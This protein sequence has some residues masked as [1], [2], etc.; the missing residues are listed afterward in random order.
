M[1]TTHAL[2]SALV[3]YLDAVKPDASI[4]VVDAR[5]RAEIALPTLAADIDQLSAHSRAL[6]HVM[7]CNVEIRLRVHAGDDA[8]A[9]VDNWNDQIESALNDPAEV[10]ALV[11]DGI[12]IDYWLYSGSS[13]DWDESM[14][15]TTFHAECLA[16]VI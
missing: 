2:K 15:E 3:A 11:S 6:A 1:N 16:R 5:Q 9:D 7:R 14:L 13:Q 10:K 12:A 8:D 4:A